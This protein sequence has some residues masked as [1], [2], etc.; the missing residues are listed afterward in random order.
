MSSHGYTGTFRFYSFCVCV[1]ATVSHLLS[2]CCFHFQVVEDA[3]EKQILSSMWRAVAP[4]HRSSH[5]T[6]F[7]NRNTSSP[8]VGRHFQTFRQYT[9]KV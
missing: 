2:Q 6:S 7:L 5:R 3:K 9:R 1:T 4:G 8:S